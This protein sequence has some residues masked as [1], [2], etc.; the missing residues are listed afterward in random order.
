MMSRKDEF[1]KKAVHW[2][3]KKNRKGKTTRKGR[4]YA[5]HYRWIADRLSG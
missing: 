5:K 1:L 4:H 2:E 3:N